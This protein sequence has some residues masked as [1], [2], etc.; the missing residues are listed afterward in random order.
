MKI[1]NTYLRYTCQDI[2]VR[3]AHAECPK[4]Q[5]SDIGALSWPFCVIRAWEDP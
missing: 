3:A 1:A 2:F 5:A 4:C